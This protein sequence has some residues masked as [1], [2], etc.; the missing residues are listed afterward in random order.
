MHSGLIIIIC[1]QGES[2]CGITIGVYII[3]VK[4]MPSI[5]LY[6]ILHI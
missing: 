6:I 2:L 3:E 5:F 1:L 4:P